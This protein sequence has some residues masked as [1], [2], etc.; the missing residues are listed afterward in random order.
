[1]N[2]YDTLTNAWVAECMSEVGRTL[3]MNAITERGCGHV[4]P[5]AS[6]PIVLLDGRKTRK[7]IINYRRDIDDAN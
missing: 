5:E 4:V 1:M 3:P 6:D 2:L 7:F